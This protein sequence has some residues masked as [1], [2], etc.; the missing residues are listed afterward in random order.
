MNISLFDFEEKFKSITIIS[1]KDCSSKDYKESRYTILGYRADDIKSFIYKPYLE[2]ETKSKIEFLNSIILYSKISESVSWALYKLEE[3]N[4]EELIQNKNILLNWANIIENWWHCDQLSSIY[5][6]ILDNH[7][8]FFK[9][10]QSFNSFSYPWHRRLSVTSLYYY[11]KNCKKPLPLEMTLPLIERLLSDE[12]YYVQK[13][14]GWTLR[15]MSQIN[16]EHTLKFLKIHAKHIAPAGFSTAL[17]KIKEKDKTYIKELRK[18]DN[19]NPHE[20]EAHHTPFSISSHKLKEDI[21]NHL[22]N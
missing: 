14:V 6:Q 19:S 2:L 9:E 7:R 4:I 5:N 10:L 3:F 11:A 15:E 16:Y 12:H 18:K 20:F 13:A 8:L 17:E 21:H 1:L 22:R